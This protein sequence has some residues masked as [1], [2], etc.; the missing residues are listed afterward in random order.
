MDVIIGVCVG[1][2]LAACCGFRVFVPL[3][4]VSIAAQNGYVELGDSFGG[5]GNPLATVVFG[6]ATAAEIVG[7]YLPW[8][9]NALD[10]IATPAASA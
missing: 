10:T 3:L 6:A 2:A 8:V 5:M 4:V 9:D 1:I 7:Y